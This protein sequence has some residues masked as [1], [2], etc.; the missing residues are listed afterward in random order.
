MK[1]KHLCRVSQ[2]SDEKA[3]E[4]LIESTFGGFL[5]GKFWKWKYKENPYFDQKLVAVIEEN[6]EI[7]G[8]NH[9]L[10]RNFK[11]S[12][13]ITDTAV[14]AADVA[15][16]PDFRGKGLGKAL[17]RFLRSSDLVKS[18]R[19]AFIYMFTELGLAKKFHAPT[20]GYILAPDGTAQYTKV[21]SWKKVKENV[22]SL[23]EEISSGKFGKKLPRNDL[24][25]LFKIHAAPPLLIHIKE[26]SLAVD[27][28]LGISEENADMV[29][30]GDLS[31]FNRIKMSKRKKSSLLKAL[32][33]GKLKIKVK[34]TKIF[35]LFNVLWIFEEIFSR[36]MT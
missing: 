12:R 8:C 29:V 14:L 4:K 26:N 7:V 32:L 19:A 33:T 9:W 35:S 10:L 25:L 13:S 24:R 3:V 2:D 6:G 17:L 18:R 5:E 22:N 20:A 23:N 28:L 31:V 27:D 21:L 1:E 34:L 11:I 15:V 30:S 16:K 36:K